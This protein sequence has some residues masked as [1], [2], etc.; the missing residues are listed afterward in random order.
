M[1]YYTYVGPPFIVSLSNN[2]V[3]FEEDRVSFMCEVTNDPDAIEDVTFVWSH[4][5]EQI[6]SNRGERRQRNRDDRI[7]INNTVETQ[8]SRTVVGTLTINSVMLR[9]TGQYTCSAL[10]HA[11]QMVNHTTQL[12]VRCKL[13]ISLN[14]HRSIAVM[15]IVLIHREHVDVYH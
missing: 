6:L 7:N 4:N 8:P 3:V 9:D 2:T 14:V 1:Y 15:Q 13:T 11:E 5:N 10:N 12:T